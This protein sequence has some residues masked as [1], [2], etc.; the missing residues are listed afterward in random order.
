MNYRK[1]K[2]HELRINVYIVLALDV[3]LKRGLVSAI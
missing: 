1:K 2:I 3:K